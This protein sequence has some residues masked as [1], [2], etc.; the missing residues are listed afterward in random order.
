MFKMLNKVVL[1]FEWFVFFRLL[2]NETENN[3]RFPENSYFTFFPSHLYF[4]SFIEF[5]FSALVAWWWR[6][7]GE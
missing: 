2:Q 6:R 4:I 1:N 5:S 7:G 3:P